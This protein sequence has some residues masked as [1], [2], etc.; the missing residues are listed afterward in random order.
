MITKD[1]KP[2]TTQKILRQKRREHK[3]QK[4]C[5]SKPQLKDVE[6][7]VVRTDLNHQRLQ[8]AIVPPQ[9]DQLKA[10]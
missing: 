5:W 2:N 10:A 4:R 8:T 3:Q 9:L 1:V 7:I 6:K